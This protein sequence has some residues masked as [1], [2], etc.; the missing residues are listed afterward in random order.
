[1]KTLLWDIDGTLLTTKGAGAI[2]FKESIEEFLN[3]KIEF[4]RDKQSGLTDHQIVQ[5]HIEQN[6]MEKTHSHLIDKIVEH[7]ATKLRD[8]LKDTPVQTY[9]GIKELLVRL[10]RSSSFNLSIATGNCS[11]GA[12]EKLKSGG[13]LEYFD[14]SRIFCSEDSGPRSNI[15]KRA[16]SKMGADA[17]SSIV[18]GDTIHDW[19]AAKEL[20]IPFILIINDERQISNKIAS[21]DGA[22]IGPNWTTLEF[23]KIIYAV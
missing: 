11:V 22:S 3:C 2:P 4:D 5:L 21:M 16:L 1:M 15:L 10:Q 17:R 9:P 13:L 8:A 19:N 6:K 18:I 23:E 20:S 7:Y 12:R 14:E